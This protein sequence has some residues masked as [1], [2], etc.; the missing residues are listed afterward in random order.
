[1]RLPLEDLGGQGVAQAFL[2]D[3]GPDARGRSRR[4]ARRSLRFPS[5]MSSSSTLISSASAILARRKNSLSA[6]RVDLVGVGPDLGLAGADVVRRDK[7][8]CCSSMTS[9]TIVLFSWRETRSA[10]RSNGVCGDQLASRIWRRIACLCCVHDPPLQ[11]RRGRRRAAR[12][13]CRSRSSRGTPD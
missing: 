8:S 10:G 7:P 2:L 5:S 9:R 4:S 1:M 6:R 11:H 13:G 3:P 12:P